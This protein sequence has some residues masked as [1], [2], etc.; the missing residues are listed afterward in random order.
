MVMA[1]VTALA[2]IYYLPDG[3][4]VK[5]Q[6]VGLVPSADADKCSIASFPHLKNEDNYNISN[7]FSSIVLRF[8]RR[9]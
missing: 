6:A 8:S 4:L 1:G 2:Y 5:S 3:D 9:T 7:S